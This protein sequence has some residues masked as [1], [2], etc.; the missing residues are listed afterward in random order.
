MMIVLLVDFLIVAVLLTADLV[1]K[2]YAASILGD[3]STFVAIKKVLSF[4]YQQN[5]GAAFGMFHDA[6]VFLCVFVGIVLL[7][8]VCFM[9]YHIVKKKYKEKGGIFL[10]VCMSMIVAGGLGNLIDRIAFGYVRDFIDYTVVYTLFKRHFAICNLADVYL[11]I[12]VILVACYLIWLIAKEGKKGKTVKQV[13]ADEEVSRAP[14]E[15]NPT[16]PEEQSKDD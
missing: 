13:A 4:R 1:S 10:H 15:A 16:L 12:G 7:A 3:G 5:T 9:G 14:Q 6:R 11:T 8:L 2:Y